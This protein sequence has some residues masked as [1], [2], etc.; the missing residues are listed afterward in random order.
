MVFMTFILLCIYR[1]VCKM[2]RVLVKRPQKALFFDCSHRCVLRQDF[3]GWEALSSAMNSAFSLP[4]L[5]YCSLNW[6]WS[7]LL[8]HC[9]VVG[10][11]KF[12]FV[13]RV[14]G[15]NFVN[16]KY[17]PWKECNASTRVFQHKLYN[18]TVSWICGES[19]CDLRPMDR[20]I[21]DRSSSVSVNS[22][23]CSNVA[24]GD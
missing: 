20:E 4:K 23:A 21:N 22:L 13:R 18:L 7:F 17:L 19:S 8:C 15:V 24:N 1:I 16:E 11:T 12:V 6:V 14:I 9:A 2:T 5:L 10:V 3:L